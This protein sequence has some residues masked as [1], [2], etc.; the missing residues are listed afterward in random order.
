MA[1][2]GSFV[3]AI[4]GSTSGQGSC[5]CCGRTAMIVA[6]APQG[7]ECGGCVSVHNHTGPMGYVGPGQ[8]AYVLESGY[9]YVGYGGDHG[10]PKRDFTCII[11][12]SSLLLLVPLLLWLLWPQP[13][14]CD[15]G[16]SSCDYLGPFGSG[17]RAECCATKNICCEGPII[18]GLSAPV[19]QPPGPVD[20]FNCA[21]DF[22]QWKTDWSAEKM[23][24]CCAHHQ[25]G[26]GQSSEGPPVGSYD[27]NSGFENFVK[28]WSSHKKYYCCT[29]AQKGCEGEMTKAQAS[30]AGFGAG[31][32]HGQGWAPIAPIGAPRR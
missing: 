15:Q 5:T 24:W 10:R 3:E 22:A 13:D 9:K 16:Y 6:S 7:E 25:R 1:Q 8:G 14:K 28:G 30:G 20:P 11:C 19:E 31:A 26:C 29:T 32:Q 4:S 18:Q 27:C 23:L 2:E 12:L 17:I 21:I